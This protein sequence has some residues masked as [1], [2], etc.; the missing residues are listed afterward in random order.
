MRH[1]PEAAVITD[2]SA[3]AGLATARAFVRR[4]ANIGLL[5]RSEKRLEAACS[6]VEAAGGKALVLPVNVT[7]PDQIENAAAAVEAEFAAIDIWLN[8]AMTTIFKPSREITPQEY[9]RVTEVTHLGQVHGMMAALKRMLPRNRV[10]I[11]QL[12]PALAYR[13]IPLQSAHC[14]A[15]HAVKGLPNPHAASYCT[16]AFMCILHSCNWRRSTHCSSTG[17]KPVLRDDRN[18]WRRYSSLTSRGYRMAAHHYRH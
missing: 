5:A 14:S 4:G 9:K 1:A 17:V 10:A 11:V 3:G 8:N 12:G 2:A 13:L 16:W 6:E 7:D 15:K 18:R